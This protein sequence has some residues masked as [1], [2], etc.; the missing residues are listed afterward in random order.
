MT[1]TASSNKLNGRVAV[2]TGASRGLGR[3]MA[4]AL[5]GAGAKLALVSR[6]PVQLEETAAAVRKAGAEAQIFPT[7]VVDEAQVLQLER[8]VI[9]RFGSVHILINNAGINVRKTVPEF[10]LDEWRSVI[11]TNLTSAFLLCR[12]F[13]PHMKGAGYG[14]IINMTSIM[15][16]ISMPAR[17][18]YSA[19]KAGLLGFTRALALELAAEAITCV[20]ISPGPFATEMNMPILNDPEK[21]AQFVSKIPMGRWG[22]VEEIGQLALFLCSDEAAFITGTDILIDGG[23]CAQ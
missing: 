23:W 6:D 15:S 19:S 16:H 18:A 10:T 8:D 9:A 11:D 22:R 21:N 7:D 3:A 1:D 13:V 14:R 4:I 20:A 12:S 5:A 2:I 17:A